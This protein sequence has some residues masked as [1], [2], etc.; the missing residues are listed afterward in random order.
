MKSCS[1]GLFHPEA[2]ATGDAFAS[3]TTVLPWWAQ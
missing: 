3:V 1:R 2:I